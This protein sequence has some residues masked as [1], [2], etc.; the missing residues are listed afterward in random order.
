M[1]GALRGPAAAGSDP[2]GP[3]AARHGRGRPGVL[4]A[5][6]AATAVAAAGA[7]AAAAAA[8]PP[9]T[10]VAEA[11]AALP[12][13]R[14][15]SLVGVA[16][17]LGASDPAASARLVLELASRLGG[18]AAAPRPGGGGARVAAVA[19]GEAEAA[20]LR[21]LMPRVR[22]AAPDLQIAF[23]PEWAG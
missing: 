7:A 19:W 21:A 23:L 9:E 13:L 8:R 14:D 2:D 22:E 16:G 4:R 5:A 17:G 3:G 20:E 1:L 12:A 10:R 11:L 15:V 18:A 6:A